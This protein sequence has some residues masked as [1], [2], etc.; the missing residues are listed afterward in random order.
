MYKTS[1]IKTIYYLPSKKKLPILVALPDA[2][3]S[4]KSRQDTLELAENSESFTLDSGGRQIFLAT[5]GQHSKYKNCT[6]KSGKPI[7]SGNTLNLHVSHFVEAINLFKPAWVVGLDAPSRPTK[8][9]TEQKKR[10]QESLAKNIKWA[11]ET[12]AL[13]DKYY[14]QVKVILPLQSQSIQHL[15]TYRQRIKSLNCD[16]VGLPMRCFKN[17]ERL[18][19]FMIVLH[20]LRI[21]DAH[22]LGSSRFGAICISAYLAR[23]NYFNTISLDSSTWRLAA[24]KGK[25]I[26]PYD[27]REVHVA[28]TK[29]LKLRTQKLPTSWQ[30]KISKVTASAGRKW[31]QG[32]ERI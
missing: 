17:D 30:K 10:F 25:L 1:G 16:S 8:N 21:Q 6:S 13:R 28:D 20:N 2:L 18:I 11:K 15:Q 9:F 14:K 12:I 31:T 26:I 32:A 19:D 29:K 22:L 23:K 27:F 5:T 7:V 24:D 4:Q 3:G